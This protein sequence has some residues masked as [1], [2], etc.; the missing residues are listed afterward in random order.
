MT[1]FLTEKKILFIL[2]V[3]ALAVRLYGIRN[4]ILDWHAFRQ[5]D[6]ASVTREYLKNGI[7][8]LRPKYHDH[9]NIQS[10]KDNPQGYRMVEFPFVNAGI[11]LIAKSLGLSSIDLLSRLSS[12]FFSLLTLVSLYFLTKKISGQKVATLSSLFF[13]IMPFS[14]YYSRV[15]LPEPYLLFFYTLAIWLFAEFLDS[16]KNWQIFASAVSMALA[17]LLKPFVLVYSLVLLTLGLSK[18]GLG[19]VK[20]WQLYFYPFIV[21]LPFVFWRE[22]ISHFPEGIPASDWLFDGDKLRFRPAWFR[23]LFWERIGKLIFGYF[24]LIFASANFLALKRMHKELFIYGSWWLG[25]LIY[26]IVVSTG[27]VRHDYYQVMTL[28][29][30]VITMGRGASL[31][32]EFLKKRFGQKMSIICITIIGGLS[33]LLS[34]QQIKGYYNINHWEYFHAGAKADQLLPEKAKVI[35]PAMGDTM[36]LYQTNRTGWPI[37]FE[38]DDKISKGATHY[39]ST[40]YDDETNLLIKNFATIHQDKEVVIIDLTQRTTSASRKEE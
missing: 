3:L 7:D 21:I 19:L 6:T 4:P 31:L 1:K 9:S 24:G 34:W 16:S 17:V 36:F 22:W 26:F 11:A 40:S 15:V 5:V 25:T 13:A 38:I 18:L 33:W 8:I 28:P 14:V 32:A 2:L 27:N 30:L 10:G 39:V 12:V 29:I 23:W 20:R 37:G 35:A